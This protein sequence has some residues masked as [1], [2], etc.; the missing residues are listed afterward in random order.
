DNPNLLTDQIRQALYSAKICAYAQGFQL[1]RAAQSEYAWH[2]DFATIAKIW[3]G[4]CIIRARFLN[5]IAASYQQNPDLTNLLL[6]DHF[7]E[8]LSEG[9]QAW[10]RSVADA[11]LNGLPV[12]ALASAL[13]YYDGYRSEHLPAN[14]IQAQ[15]DFFGAHTYERIDQPRGRRFHFDWMGQQQETPVE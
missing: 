7:R 14:L 15:R 6:A 9:H 3:R 5:L 1:L 2:F 10:R 12:P 8:V 13:A 4:G 11:V